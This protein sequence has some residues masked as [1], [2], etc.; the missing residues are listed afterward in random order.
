VV[1]A[2]AGPRRSRAAPIHL[3]AIRRHFA[4][5]LTARQ[6]AAVHEAMEALL[7]APR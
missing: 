4:G 3:D 7:A 1:G 2:P 6:V 5:R